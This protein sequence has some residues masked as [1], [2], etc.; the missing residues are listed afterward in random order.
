M[1]PN[2]EAEVKAVE[3]P[4]L[5]SAIR[6]HHE[7]NSNESADNL[8]AELSKANYLAAMMTNNMDIVDGIAQEGSTF[9][10]GL[11]KDEEGR[12]LLPIF[13]DWI[14]LNESAPG[15]SGLVLSAGWAYSM[16]SEEFDGVVINPTGLALPL[17]KDF[18]QHL[19][20]RK[21]A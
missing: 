5:V 20:A 11:I 7:L 21:N 1:T 10:L 16:G 12:M 9:G 2:S 19:V 8:T 4:S 17:Y 15:K 14:H 3:N 18:L 6:E 13:T